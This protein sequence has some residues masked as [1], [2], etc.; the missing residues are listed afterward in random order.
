MFKRLSISFI[1]SIILSPLCLSAQYSGKYDDFYFH[2]SYSAK[3]E[4]LGRISSSVPNQAVS[5]HYNSAL[6]GFEEGVSAT[7]NSSKPY[8]FANEVY[9]NYA[10]IAVKPFERWAFGLAQ[11]NYFGPFNEI[12]STN[13]LAVV[14]K[15]FPFLSTGINL[16]HLYDKTRVGQLLIGIPTVGP[17]NTL[18]KYN[19]LYVDLTSAFKHRYSI[20]ET[21]GATLIAGVTY[22]NVFRQKMIRENFDTY[23]QIPSFITLSANHR[24]EWKLNDSGGLLNHFSLG[25]LAEY[26]EIFQYE[27]KDRLSFGTELGFNRFIFLRGGYFQQDYRVTRTGFF[28]TGTVKKFTYGFGTE[29]P[30]SE[31]WNL[32]FR[33]NL[34]ADLSKMDQP[35]YNTFGA[36]GGSFTSLNISVNV[37]FP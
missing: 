25:I 28:E 37:A 9:F 15:P 32:P 8:K 3:S 29:I 7:F 33:L 2:R 17:N 16:R 27:R 13:T 31:I 11:A 22:H 30:V 35:A 10:G 21:G 20:S 34:V 23:V 18:Y 19:K 24:L 6:L 36:T 1:L 12:T 14:Y 26:L 4:A 5:I